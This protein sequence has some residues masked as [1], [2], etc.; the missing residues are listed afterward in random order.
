MEASPSPQSVLDAATKAMEKVE[1][2]HIE[3]YLHITPESG[4]GEERTSTSLEIDA[5]S[6]D[7]FRVCLSQSGSSGMFES[8][9]VLIGDT[10][11][12]AYTHSSEWEIG[13]FSGESFD[14]LDFT[15]EEVMSN[16]KEPSYDGL[17]ILNDIKVHSVT[18]TVSAASLG[19]TALLGYVIR[20]TGELKI[21]YWIG[22]DDSLVRRFVAEGKV[23]LAGDEMVDLLVSVDVSDFG[24]VRVET[25]VT[26][27]RPDTS[28]R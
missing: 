2:Y 18:G 3:L 10:V 24:A 8:Q 7:R 19:S 6:P 9:S 17:E 1:S 14:Y 26:G 28:A 21:V 13:E 16:I 5:Q 20:G 27:V 22:V 11:Y 15:S 12:T 25:P 4:N 23:E